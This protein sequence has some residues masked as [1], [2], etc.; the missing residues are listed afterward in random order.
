MTIV[1]GVP[2]TRDEELHEAI[3]RIDIPQVYA[4]YII[5]E[6]NKWTNRISRFFSKKAKQYDQAVLLQLAFLNTVYIHLQL[7]ETE[8]QTYIML[9][10]L[11]YAQAAWGKFSKTRTLIDL[12]LKQDDLLQ[13]IAENA[14]NI[15]LA[16]LLNNPNKIQKHALKLFKEFAKQHKKIRSLIKK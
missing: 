6:H 12:A 2:L 3:V 9:G 7:E 4:D 16:D 10:A 15:L 8:K 5:I 13:I 1:N 14:E 11:E